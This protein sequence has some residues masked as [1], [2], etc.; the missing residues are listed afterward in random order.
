MRKLRGQ[1]LGP[2]I[3]DALREIAKGLRETLG[4]EEIEFPSIENYTEEGLQRRRLK[5]LRAIVK[6]RRK[7]G[8]EELLKIFM[9]KKE[10]I[11]SREIAKE[12]GC[13]Y[14]I[15]LRKYKKVH[16]LFQDEGLLE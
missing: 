4:K 9:L 12:L 10:E 16:K 2:I 6:R 1:D 5:A 15:V 3:S 7:L 13:S 8:P 14:T 11:S